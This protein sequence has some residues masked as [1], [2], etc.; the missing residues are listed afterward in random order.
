MDK[1]SIV[2]RPRP[3]AT[4]EAELNALC[5]VYR[6]VLFESRARKEG[7]PAT[8]PNDR[9]GLEIDPARPQHTKQLRRALNSA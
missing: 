2:H 9:K 7:G 5:A 8:A 3:D 1:V 4:A 6:F